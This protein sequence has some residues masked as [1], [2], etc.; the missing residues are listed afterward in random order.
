MQNYFSVGLEDVIVKYKY[1]CAERL[2]C[3]VSDSLEGLDPWPLRASDQAQIGYSLAGQ[4][5]ERQSM[6]SLM[7]ETWEIDFFVCDFWTILMVV[8][9]LGLPA[10]D[11]VFNLF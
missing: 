7:L 9:M 1:T 6:K 5:T 11:A 2:G 8:S 10:H 4:A 3:H